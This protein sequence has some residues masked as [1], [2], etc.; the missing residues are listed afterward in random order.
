MKT[1][2]GE[3]FEVQVP[4]DW[5]RLEQP[6]DAF[7]LADPIGGV[8]A[9]QISIAPSSTWEKPTVPDLREVIAAMAEANQLSAPVASS[10]FDGEA[11]RGATADFRGGEDFIRVWCVSEGTGFALAT[12]VCRTGSEGAEAEVTEAIVRSLK[13]ST[14]APVA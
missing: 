11:L 9:L 3:G 12:Y 10:Y 7:T 1:I 8:G 4:D 5:Q 13:F 6:G 14:P 2:R